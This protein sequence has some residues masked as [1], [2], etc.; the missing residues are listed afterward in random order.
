MG[1]AP[2][3][4]GECTI[5]TDAADGNRWLG[6]ERRGRGRGRQEQVLPLMQLR[7]TKEVS[8]SSAPERAR[9]ADARAT[10]IAWR[11]G[12]G[13]GGKGLSETFP[14]ERN[15]SPAFLA[16]SSF[17]QASEASNVV[18]EACRGKEI[19]PH[20]IAA[21]S[22]R[23]I[24]EIFQIQPRKVPT[25]DNGRGITS[26]RPVQTGS[27]GVQAL[28]QYINVYKTIY[29]YTCGYSMLCSLHRFVHVS[30]SDSL[31][32]PSHNSCHLGRLEP[33]VGSTRAYCHP[34]PHRW[35]ARKKLSITPCIGGRQAL[36][37]DRPLPRLRCCVC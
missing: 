3:R 1:A 24:W 7:L 25:K 9:G 21:W 23:A 31:L 13:V 27:N 35:K 18:G 10:I 22:G 12:D 29:I 19:H 26:R 16:C 20:P 33:S 14:M 11:G 37:K 28:C 5:R 6:S 15:F 32:L 4:P 2:H 8:Q 34:G 17:N 30:Y 36:R